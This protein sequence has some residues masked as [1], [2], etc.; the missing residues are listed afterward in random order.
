M[1]YLPFNNHC[2]VV[3]NYH[4]KFSVLQCGCFPGR[5]HVLV[6]FQMTLGRDFLSVS[7]ESP[8]VGIY[9]QPRLRYV[10]EAY[11]KQ[12]NLMLTVVGN[13]GYISH[14]VMCLAVRNTIF[15]IITKKVIP[16]VNNLRR[17]VYL[18]AHWFCKNSLNNIFSISFVNAW[19]HFA[20]KAI[21]YGKDKKT[22]YK[23]MNYLFYQLYFVQYWVIFVYCKKSFVIFIRLYL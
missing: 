15:N 2:W 9:R 11:S 5:Q 13:W 14:L 12:T 4:V 3:R 20:Q 7:V 1:Q 18:H 23:N 17:K 10:C 6:H 22:W 8:V 21:V 16:Q 19:I